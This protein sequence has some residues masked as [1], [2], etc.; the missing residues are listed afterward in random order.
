M[1][2]VGEYCW[3]CVMA[4]VP[5]F[6]V[7]PLLLGVV[8]GQGAGGFTVRGFSNGEGALILRLNLRARVFRTAEEACAAGVPVRGRSPARFRTVWLAH[9]DAG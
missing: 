8:V 4:S 7:T 2:L 1:P 5:P 3:T 6:G 9:I